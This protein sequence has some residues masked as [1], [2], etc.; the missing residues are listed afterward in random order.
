M[1]FTNHVTK[2]VQSAAHQLCNIGRIRQYLTTDATRLLIQALVTSRLDY[3]KSLLTGIPDSQLQRLQKVQNSATRIITFTK[4]SQHITP[5]L[6]DLHWLPIRYR[7]QHKV[8][9]HAYKA[10][11][12]TA[13]VY[14]CDLVKSYTPAR[15]LRSQDLNL[16]QVPRTRSVTYGDRRFGT[17]A[18]TLWNEL[19]QHIRT[20]GSVSVFKRQLKPNP[21]LQASIYLASQLH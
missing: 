19:P 8:L 16:L 4:R 18:P 15:S 1:R 3:G 20:A 13:P 5:V 9:T 17:M 11:N 10:V 7:I 12:N 14:I 2:V 21:F 6:M